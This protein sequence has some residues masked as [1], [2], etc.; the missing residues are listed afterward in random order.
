MD[1]LNEA[2]SLALRIVHC[3]LSFW[4]GQQL[5]VT[6][7]MDGKLNKLFLMRHL[8]LLVAILYRKSKK[9]ERARKYGPVAKIMGYHKD[10]FRMNITTF[11]KLVLDIASAIEGKTDFDYLAN[12]P[13]RKA[14]CIGIEFMAGNYKNYSK[15]SR[16]Y[17]IAK[18]NGIKIVDLFLKSICLLHSKVVQWPNEHQKQLSKEHYDIEY[19]FPG[20]VGIIDGTHINIVNFAKDE[21]KID[22]TDRKSTYSVNLTV[23]INE[24]ERVIAANYGQPGRESDS[25]VFRLMKV[26]ENPDSHFN[27]SEY[28]FGDKAYGLSKNLITPYKGVD[29]NG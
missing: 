5:L 12:F 4:N 9:R 15:L 1:N 21:Q 26:Y 7:A 14:M 8:L 6:E 22:F 19:G 23:I 24:N 10:D 28:L 2:M 18:G 17:G 25:G 11:N 16:Q 20:L 29:I 27:E 13:L 3:V